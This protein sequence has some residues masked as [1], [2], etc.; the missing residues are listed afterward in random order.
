MPRKRPAVRD[1][2]SLVRQQAGWYRTPDDRFEVRRQGRRWFLTDAVQPDLPRDPFRTMRLAREAIPAA[3]SATTTPPVAAAPTEQPAWRRASTLSWLFIGTAALLASTAVIGSVAGRPAGATR[4]ASPAPTGSL[5]AAVPSGA[6][7][8][9]D[10][11]SSS[12]TSSA[13]SSTGQS[14]AATTPS[15]RPTPPP[16]PTPAPTPAVASVEDATGDAVDEN[17]TATD[18]PGYADIVEVA[19]VEEAGEWVLTITTSAALEWRDPFSEPLRYGFA[20]D[21]DQDGASNFDVGM[22]NDGVEGA[23]FGSLWNVEEGSVSAGT[24]F[25]GSVEA[26]G[27]SAVIHLSAEAIGTPSLLGAIGI[28]DRQAWADPINDPLNVTES[29][30]RAPGDDWIDVRRS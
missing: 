10:Q 28:M 30:D 12:G 11:P 29:H 20:I 26:T 3:R 17:G 16:T 18:A 22:E 9:S 24:E 21:T 2:D 6:A 5:V 8:E 19:V 13:S 27:T 1:P 14:Q 4:T 23:W 25:P 15:A 7:D